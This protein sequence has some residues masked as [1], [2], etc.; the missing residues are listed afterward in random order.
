MY[1]PHEYKYAGTEFGVRVK[2]LGLRV[3]G[4]CVAQQ[5]CGALHAGHT[6]HKQIHPS[7]SVREVA[8][9]Q[10]GLSFKAG[11]PSWISTAQH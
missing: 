2:S 7:L 8:C 11:R 10:R 4:C 5:R 9:L 1:R 3:Q 6:L